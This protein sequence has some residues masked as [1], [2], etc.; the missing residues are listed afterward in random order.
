MKDFKIPCYEIRFYIKW[1]GD[2]DTAI[3]IGSKLCWSFKEA[4]YHLA[5]KIRLLDKQVKYVKIDEMLSNGSSLKLVRHLKAEEYQAEL[6]KEITIQEMSY[7]MLELL[8][9]EL[10]EYDEEKAYHVHKIRSCKY[11]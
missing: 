4:I 11:A 6:E 7:T 9:K 1:D 8:A 5:L 3:D 2:E 10:P